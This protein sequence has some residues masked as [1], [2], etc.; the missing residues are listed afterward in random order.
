VLPNKTLSCLRIPAAVLLLPL[1]LAGCA[2]GASTGGGGSPAG[3]PTHLAPGASADAFD[4]GNATS[5]QTSTSVRAGWVDL[6]SGTKGATKLA[7]A[8]ESSDTGRAIMA[9]KLFSPETKVMEDAAA[10]DMIEAFSKQGFDRFSAATSPEAAPST[11]VGAIWLE[12][13]GQ[14]RTLFLVRGAAQ[15]AQTADLPKVYEGLKFLVLSIHNN[16]P[17]FSISTGTGP[18]DDSIFRQKPRR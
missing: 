5:T 1:L 16:T 8:S 2:S 9:A 13:G 6:R 12:V 10:Q 7:L 4:E 14:M 17:G 18:A 15:N 3:R 11:A